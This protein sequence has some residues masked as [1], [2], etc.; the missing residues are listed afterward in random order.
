[1]STVY[2]KNSKLG[3]IAELNLNFS[4]STEKTFLSKRSH[5][6]PLTIQRPFYP[7]GEICH[8]YFSQ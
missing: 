2:N 6:G 8:V 3:W 1:M 7:E 5:I 4:R